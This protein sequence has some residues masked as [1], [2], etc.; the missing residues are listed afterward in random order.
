[1]SGRS[2]LSFGGFFLG[3]AV[4]G[5]VAALFTPFSGK[6]LREKVKEKVDEAK[7]GCGDTAEDI[8]H[9]SDEAISGT[10]SSIEE[11][12]NRL[13]EAITE[14]QKAAEEKREELTGG[15]Q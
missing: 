12:I 3:A 1:M 10:I 5:A 4:A 9:N 11:G 2:R 8:R 15:E 6:E 7:K 13:T 14:A